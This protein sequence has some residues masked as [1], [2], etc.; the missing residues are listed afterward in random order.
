MLCY[1]ASHVTPFQSFFQ[2][3]AGWAMGQH[4]NLDFDV[5]SVLMLTGGSAW[6]VLARGQKP[7]RPLTGQSMRGPLFSFAHH[8][9]H[10]QN[11]PSPFFQQWR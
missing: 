8:Y 2:V 5:F 3:L 10:T 1:R 11:N 4:F 6:R 7:N 9:T